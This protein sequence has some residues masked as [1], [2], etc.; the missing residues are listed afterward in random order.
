M[1]TIN[2]VGIFVTNKLLGTYQ[3]IL[4]L[5]LFSNEFNTPLFRVPFL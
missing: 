3:L 2:I 5:K 1:P 4:V